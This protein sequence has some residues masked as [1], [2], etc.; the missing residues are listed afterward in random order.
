MIIAFAKMRK[1]EGGTSLVVN[2][3]LNINIIYNI[4]NQK[5]TKYTAGET[6]KKIIL[7]TNIMPS[8]QITILKNSFININVYNMLSAKRI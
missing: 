2:Q 5:Q 4:K 3:E 7:L 8:V 1:Y 6:V